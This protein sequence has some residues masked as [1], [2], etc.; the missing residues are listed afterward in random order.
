[1]RPY[2]VPPKNGIGMKVDKGRSITIIDVDGGQAADF[3]AEVG[4][5]ARHEE[6]LSPAAT[7]DC[8]ES[9]HM[10]VGTILYSNKYR[11]M[12]KVE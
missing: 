12:F 9:L 2:R 4:G 7:I 6:Y 3:F 10:G 5:G 1:M 11:P 8:N